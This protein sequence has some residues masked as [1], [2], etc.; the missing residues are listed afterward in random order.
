MSAHTVILDPAA[1]PSQPV[2]AQVKTLSSV[3]G[4]TV[5]IIDNTKPN[6]DLLAD[7]MAALL[8]GEHGASRIVRHRKRAPSDG[9]GDAVLDALRQDC[10]LVI[11][12]SG[13]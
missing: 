5:A 4:K 9:A 12:G 10:D 8:V 2:E 1:P 6:F 11:A 7:D 13:D 3:R